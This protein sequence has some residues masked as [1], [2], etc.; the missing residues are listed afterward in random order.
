MKQRNLFYFFTI[1]CLASGF[2]VACSDKD[3]PQYP[4]FMMPSS[5]AS[6][7]G[8]S[9]YFGYDDYGR[10]VS[11]TMNYGEDKAVAS[12]SYPDNN[13]ILVESSEITGTQKRTFSETI[14]LE[15][16]RATKAEGI[17]LQS[18]I[19]A[20]DSPVSKTYRLEFEYDKFKGHLIE[21]KHAEITG[22]AEGNDNSALD[23]AWRWS[24]YLYWEDGNLKEYQVFQGHSSVWQT[25][26][27]EYS[28]YA[29]G[30]PIVVPFIINSYHHQPLI[31]KE[32]F[33]VNSKNYV[34]RVSI[35]DANGNIPLIGEYSYHFENGYLNS[36]TETYSN[37]STPLSSVNYKVT[38]TPN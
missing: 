38:W 7:N 29:V 14:T 16:G 1:L 19:E 21:I 32:V 17:F 24:D 37:G 12:F 11:W 6:D 4:L 27:Y 10:I 28:D 33:G 23:N 13:T 5:I 15:N 9:E 2:L 18:S 36:F 35:S 34:S 8:K 26:T 31:M 20:E 30:Y 22:I 25:R 3:E